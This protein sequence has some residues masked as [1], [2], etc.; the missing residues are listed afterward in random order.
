MTDV[1]VVVLVVPVVA[2][3]SGSKMLVKSVSKPA[4]F[5]ALPVIEFWLVVDE[6][7]DVEDVLVPL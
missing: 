3:L 1:S 5:T 6:V 4:S 2:L 7:V